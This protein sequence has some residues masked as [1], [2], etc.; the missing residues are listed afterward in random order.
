MPM[1]F[2]DYYKLNTA[3]EVEERA[4]NRRTW[5]TLLQS[6]GAHQLNLL[7]LGESVSQ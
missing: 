2:G 7:R 3:Q 5:T 6:A 4:I 1:V